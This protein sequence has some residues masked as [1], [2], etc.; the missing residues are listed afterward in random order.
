MNALFEGSQNYVIDNSLL[1]KRYKL[2]YKAVKWLSA[3]EEEE[4]EKEEEPIR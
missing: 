1:D 4:E 2:R 3:S